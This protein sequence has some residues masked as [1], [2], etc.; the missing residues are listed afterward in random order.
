M[1]LKQYRKKATCDFWDTHW[2]E[3]SM[4]DLYK[5]I[6]ND[7]LLKKMTEYL[8]KDGKIIEGGCGLGQYVF[9][10]KERGYD[11][12]G[13]DFA[14]K[15]ISK[16]NVIKPEL[17]VRFG[18]VYA[19]NY[20]DSQFNGYISLGVIEHDEEGPQ[21]ML[22]EIARVLKDEGVLFI[23]V[24][25]YSL[26]R[27]LKKFLSFYPDNFSN[28]KEFYQ[29]YF[30]GKEL[31]RHLKR[32]GFRT[33]KVIP[34]HISKGIKDELSFLAHS[35]TKFRNE[36]Q[37]CLDDGTKGIVDDLHKYEFKK[38]LKRLLL[39]VSRYLSNNFILSIFL[40][41]MLLAV[42]RLDKNDQG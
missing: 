7:F 10:L 36:N 15:T 31:K 33:I 16:L 13:I 12:E 9:G 6:S 5:G 21:K 23:T 35:I 17:P 25:Y 26:L 28:N 11:I 2:E 29:Y 3:N 32:Q 19:H 40:G 42:A 34:F 24:P 37:K 30:T 39:T 8:Q 20:K 1:V 14:R 18:D 27:R 38:I 4:V 22:N 41:H